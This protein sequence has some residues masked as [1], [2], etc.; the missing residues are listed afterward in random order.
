LL[1]ALLSA[2]A[3]S[4]IEI[5]ATKPQATIA[6]VI[7]FLFMITLLMLNFFGNKKTTPK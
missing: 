4:G 1:S 5:A 6:V 3:I 7:V 2:P